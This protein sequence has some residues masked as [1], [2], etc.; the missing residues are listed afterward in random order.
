MFE[1]LE[2]PNYDWE[3]VLY[4]RELAAL[5]LEVPINYN[6]VRPCLQFTKR[7]QKCKVGPHVSLTHFGVVF[8]ERR[9]WWSRDLH[10]DLV[11]D[12]NSV[13]TWSSETGF[14]TWTDLRSGIETC[15]ETW[16]GVETL[17]FVRE[18]IGCARGEDLCDFLFGEWPPSSSRESSHPHHGDPSTELLHPCLGAS[19]VI[20]FCEVHM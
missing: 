15:I 1:V 12:L 4:T 10:R 6:V 5:Y 2:Q 20:H 16:T 9:T 17:E 14:R 8:S 7:H 18:R 13:G 11:Q 3:H 19:Q